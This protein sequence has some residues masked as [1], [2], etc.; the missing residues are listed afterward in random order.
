KTEEDRRTALYAVAAIGGPEAKSMLLAAALNATDE[1]T[2]RD[3]TFAL[4]E[5][6]E[7]G[8]P[9]QELLLQLYRQAKLPV[10]RRAALEALVDEENATPVS[11]LAELLKS[12]KDPDVRETLI[13]ALTET[14]KDEA[15]V[16]LYDLAVNDPD[17]RTRTRAIN[18]LGEIKSPKSR[19]ALMNILKK[20]DAGSL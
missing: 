17:L 19:E 9:R 12:E 4:A 1:E 11:L 10:V 2:A 7:K 6:G 14:K 18:A 16:A 3:A 13:D 15:V 20:K 5:T 8:R